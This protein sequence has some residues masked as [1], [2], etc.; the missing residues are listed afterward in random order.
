[1]R[2]TAT[3]PTEWSEPNGSFKSFLHKMAHNGEFRG[4]ILAIFLFFASWG[5]FCSWALH[6]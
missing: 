6:R 1:M 3:T 2:N 5:G 4:D